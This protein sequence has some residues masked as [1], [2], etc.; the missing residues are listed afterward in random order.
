MKKFESVSIVI[1]TV[2]EDSSLRETVNTLLNTCNHSDI[3]ELYLLV[4]SRATNECLSAI[5]DIK[6][7]SPVP[8]KVFRQSFPGIG[9]NLNEF[10]M[11]PT[12]SHVM[13]ISA[14]GNL[15]PEQVCSFIE[16]A[17]K[18]PDYIIVGS[19]WLDKHGFDNYDPFKK[20]LNFAG[21]IFLSVLFNTNRTEFTQP[22]QI[23]P[24]EIFRNIRWEEHMHPLFMEVMIK[25]IRLGVKSTEIPTQ[26]KSRREGKPNRNGLYFVPYL[27]TA[28]HVRF[29][30]K[31]DMLMPGCTIPDELLDKNKGGAR[32]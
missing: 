12:G 6:S 31:A 18:T 25:P 8:V 16:Y 29:M 27:K 1:S 3:A 26:W 2:N 13:C 28:L 5:E 7:Y 15:D 24:I 10:F 23:C 20:V 22:F 21:R 9:A 4:G 17:K 19:R 30:K 14:D 11:L 32:K